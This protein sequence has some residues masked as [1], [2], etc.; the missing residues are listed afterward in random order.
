MLSD[1]RQN[2]ALTSSIAKP[3][4]H[5]FHSTMDRR[6]RCDAK[7]CRVSTITTLIDEI[8][9]DEAI[10][11][12]QIQRE[13]ERRSSSYDPALMG[14]E[15]AHNFTS[16]SSLLAFLVSHERY[17]ADHQIWNSCPNLQQ[18]WTSSTEP[19]FSTFLTKL[20]DF[21]A[22]T[23]DTARSLWTAIP[24]EENQISFLQTLALR[25]QTATGEMKSTTEPSRFFTQAFEELAAKASI[26]FAS[27]DNRRFVLTFSMVNSLMTVNKFNRGGSLASHTFNIHQD[28]AAFLRFLMGLACCDLETIGYDT[29]V[30]TSPSF[31]PLRTVTSAHGMPYPIHEVLFITDSLHGR[32]TVVWHVELGEAVLVVKDCWQDPCRLFTEGEI[33]DHLAEAGVIG[34]V[35]V[36]VME[37]PVKAKRWKKG[38]PG[39][40]FQQ[41][42]EDDN[43]L[44]EHPSILEDPSLNLDNFDHRLHTC[45]WSVPKGITIACFRSQIEL[46]VALIDIIIVHQLCFIV[47]STLHRDFSINNLFLTKQKPEGSNLWYKDPR[48]PVSRVP[49]ILRGMMGDL[50]YARISPEGM[51]ELEKIRGRAR[52][53]QRRKAGTI[54]RDRLEAYA[55]AEDL[56]EEAR[57]EALHRTG[58]APYMATKLTMMEEGTTVVHRPHHD[59]ESAFLVLLSLCIIFEIPGKL[60][61]DLDFDKAGLGGWMNPRDQVESSQFRMAFLRDSVTFEC[62]VLTHVSPYFQCLKPCLRNLQKRIYQGMTMKDN[63]FIHDDPITYNDIILEL[64]SALHSMEA[65]PALFQAAEEATL[66]EP[67]TD[68]QEHGWQNNFTSFEVIEGDREGVSLV[69]PA[70][71]IASPSSALSP[72]A[73]SSA[74]TTGSHL[75]AGSR[76]LTDAHTYLNEALIAGQAQ[77]VTSPPQ[78]PLA[79]ATMEEIRVTSSSGKKKRG[80][81]QFSESPT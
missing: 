55:S 80:G 37:Y 52:L 64:T 25:S 29:T 74:S 53:L 27:Q 45:L 2:P 32:G 7:P 73:S 70:L 49:G 54:S 44:S 46:V 4:K 51:T 20:L 1:H 12:T 40:G 38:G 71:P 65:D 26:I 57:Q 30:T 9:P 48:P 58:T 61:T 15:T 41:V 60:R 47:A 79:A 66:E 67:K 78:S 76:P 18:P 43:T 39:Q 11:A 13:E 21:V 31:Q 81:T 23:A 68:W 62:F 3:S 14:L 50:G 35:P 42:L 19:D 22:K 77:L 5:Y 69:P 59:G 8:F 33:L 56:V 17:N 34:G 10:F 36:K 28:P 72:F 6:V 24:H 16:I 75:S 63:I